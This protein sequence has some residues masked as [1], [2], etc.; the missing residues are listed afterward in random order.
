MKT[1]KNLN[2]VNLEEN[3]IDGESFLTKEELNQLV[4]SGIGDAEGEGGSAGKVPGC[5]SKV[6]GFCSK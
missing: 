1:D 6:G 4:G 2:S 5:D 3:L